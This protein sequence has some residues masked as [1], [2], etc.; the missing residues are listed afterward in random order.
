MQKTQQ[1]Q[2]S[3]DT[4]PHH[5]LVV[6]D[7]VSVARGLEM[8]LTDEG[9]AVNVAVNGN[10]ALHMFDGERFD[11]VVADLRLPDIDG[12]E[13]LQKVKLDRPETKAIVITGYPN[14]SSAIKA[15]RIGVEDY[16][17]KP[18]TDDEFI[19]VVGQV[20]RREQEPSMEKFLQAAEG[21][22][23]I[24]RQEVI[25]ALET[26]AHERDFAIQL[27][28]D[29]SKAL[30]NYDLSAEAKAAIVTGD[31]SWIRRHIGKLTDAQLEWVYRRLEVEK[32]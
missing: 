23:L 11:M 27:L 25:R 2:T 21:Q 3:P 12:L 7:E 18:F 17:S 19:L 1:P 13:V 31:L 15:L 26:A 30:E 28:E 32:W 16:L 5:I 6:E 10:D 20:L 9:Y 29:G 24:Q 22:T 14:V 4:Q 8:I